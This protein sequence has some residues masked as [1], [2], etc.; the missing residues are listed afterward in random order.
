MKMRMPERARIRGLYAI[1]PDLDDTAHLCTLIEASLDGGAAH[2][3]YRNKNP[4][5][6]FRA[7]QA[8]QL[9]ALCRRHGVPLIINDHA[10]LCLAL[11]AD[12]VHLGRDDGDIAS[13]RAML[14]DKLLGVSCYASFEQA[15]SAQAQ[16]ADYVAFGSC[17]GSNTKPDAVRAPLT[18]FTRATR[19]LTVPVV[20]IGGITADN[21]RLALDAGADCIAVIDALFG[22]ANV[23]QAATR[24]ST[25]FQ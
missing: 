2:V 19:E 16:G 11:G 24:F 15:Q 25:L 22:A 23:Q 6:E 5:A 9:L 13:V 3:Q 4:D 20:A 17:F 10:D 12:G 8:G 1:T 14:G 7:T 21:A 18:L